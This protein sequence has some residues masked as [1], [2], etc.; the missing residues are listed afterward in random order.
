MC[1]TYQW[2]NELHTVVLGRVV[3]CCDHD[4]NPFSLQSSRSEGS[5]ESNACED[6]VKDIA[7]AVSLGR[8]VEYA[9]RWVDDKAVLR[10]GT[11]L[12]TGQLICFEYARH[13]DLLQ[14]F[15]KCKQAPQAQGAS[16]QRRRW[17]QTCWRVVTKG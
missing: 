5:D 2:L 9:S 3:G 12:Y 10:F 4:T 17:G 13:I 11:E 6:R 14:R 15:R 1:S 7:A 16:A 8:G